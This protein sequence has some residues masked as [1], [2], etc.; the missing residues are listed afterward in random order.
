MTIKNLKVKRTVE[1][2]SPPPP[3]PDKYQRIESFYGD[4]WQLDATFPDKSKTLG[5]ALS[6][7]ITAFPG[8]QPREWRAIEIQVSAL[9]PHPA[10]S[11]KGYPK[12]ARPALPGTVANQLRIAFEMVRLPGAERQADIVRALTEHMREIGKPVSPSVVQRYYRQWLDAQKHP[13]KK[14]IPERALRF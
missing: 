4:H 9:L 12:G 10:R 11:R 8:I 3:L 7:S 2:I 14:Y 13:K 5:T 6:V 1:L